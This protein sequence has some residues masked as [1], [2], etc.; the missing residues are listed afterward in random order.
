MVCQTL[1]KSSSREPHDQ[2]RWY[3]KLFKNLIT[4]NH[5]TKMCGMPN[6]S[7]ILFQRTT[8]PKCVVCQTLQNSSSR[9]PHD[10]NRWYA[11]LIKTLPPE[12]LCFSGGRSLEVFSISPSLVITRG[13]GMPFELCSLPLS[14]E[15]PYTVH[16]V[17]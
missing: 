3:A 1:Q 16:S 17:A 15:G 4:E 9:E 11:K 8:L 6:S 10:Q 12:N 2:N 13:H 14:L 7:K 5:M